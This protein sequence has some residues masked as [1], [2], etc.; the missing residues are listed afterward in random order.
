METKYKIGIC[1]SVIILSI[2]IPLSQSAP[3]GPVTDHWWDYSWTY[4]LVID[5][6]E[7]SGST[8]TDYQVPITVNMSTFDYNKANSSGSD[9]RFTLYNSTTDNETEISYWIEDWN[10]SGESVIWVNVTEIPAS[11]TATVYMYYGNTGA[12]AASN[13]S[14]TM[15]WFDD[16]STDTTSQYSTI[17]VDS[18]PTITSG[19]MEFNEVGPG[20]S[21][22]SIVYPT[23][24]GDRTDVEINTR[25][26]VSSGMWWGIWVRSDINPVSPTTYGFDAKPSAGA[27]DE[28]PVIERFDTGIRTQLPGARNT[29]ANGNWYDARGRIWGTGSTVYLRYKVSTFPELSYD[30]T[31]GSRITSAGKVGMGAYEATTVRYDYFEVRKYTS[32]EPTVNLGAEESS[33]GWMDYFGGTV[34]TGSLSN[35]TVSGGDVELAVNSE[36]KT[37][38]SDSFEVNLSKWDDNGPTIWDLVGDRYYDGTRS[39]RANR[40]NDG[41]ITSDDIDLSDATV[42]DL[43]FWIN[44]DD[45]D[46]TDITLYFYD[47]SSWNLISELDGL[48]G[49]DTWLNYVNNS[50]DLGTYGISNFRI[51]FDATLGAGERV[52]V[53]RLVLN[54]TLSSYRSKGSI[55]SINITPEKFDGW[56]MFHAND[57]I[58]EGYSGWD[59]RKPIKITNSSTE[60]T[61]YQINLTVFHVPGKMNSDFSD[62]RF[63]DDSNN[64]LSYWIESYVASTSADV[65]VKVPIIAASGNTT[66]YMYYGNA[67]ATSTS[68]GDAT[69]DFFDDF[70]DGNISD[71]SQYGSGVIQIA[72]DSGN[73]VLLK[74]AQNDPNGGYSLFNNGTLSDFEAIFRTKRINE[75]GGAQNRY[76]LEDSSHNGYGPRITDFNSLPSTFAIE[77]RNGGSSG[78]NLASKSSS[79]PEWDTWMTIKFRR[80]GDTLEFEL[81]NSSGDL[82]ESISVSDSSYSSF[83]RFVVHGGNEFY[84]DD[85]RT[86]KYASPEPTIN[87]ENEE[88]GYLNNISYKILNAA[89]DSPICTITS[90]EANAGYDISSC[91]SGVTSIKLFAD[92][93]TTDASYTPILHD[94]N[95]SWTILDLIEIRD[96]NNETLWANNSGIKGWNFFGSAG[97]NITVTYQDPSIG[98]P[99]CTIWLNGTGSK[100]YIYS[101]NFTDGAGKEFNPNATEK[102]VVRDHGN[103]TPINWSSISLYISNKNE[104]SWYNF[105]MESYEVKDV[106]LQLNVPAGTK[107]GMYNANFTATMQI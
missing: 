94:W 101:A 69:F 27:Y 58:T 42:V 28:R 99:T 12:G 56:S 96:E 4:R 21:D 11:S 29:M 91:A 50:I 20:S 3:S 7:E 107:T 17:G 10:T 38:F 54:K 19:Y 51:R 87:F 33:T 63:K 57:G 67:N 48:G 40:N 88:G 80:Y 61:D 81:Y 52:W 47:G 8:L 14:E 104:T 90:E 53:D 32:P 71:W 93:T 24:L 79:A 68:D 84:T 105:T 76:G 34:G 2:L 73:N 100:V 66:I 74:T 37:P 30:D 43:N 46:G 1:V 85:I 15:L 59:Y 82:N 26:M 95:V 78:G 49:D 83:D 5:V 75:N 9:I 13:R 41:Y 25:V 97:D 98:M 64:V 102:I 70:E 23:A 55:T 35:V 89:D 36:I 44:K 77:I 16:F 45:T 18:G 39:V 92:L 86:R 6:T 31:S 22:H 60:L 103:T 62:L 72:N 106:Y 65:W